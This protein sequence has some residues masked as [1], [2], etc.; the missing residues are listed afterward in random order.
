[1]KTLSLRT[2]AVVLSLFTVVF[3]LGLLWLDPQPVQ[4]LR[5]QGFDQFQR[6]QPRPYEPVGVRVVDLDDESLA[7]LGQWPWPRTRMAELVQALDGLGAAAIG[8]DVVFAEPDRTS[9]RAVVDQW[10]LA[11]DIRESLLRLPDHD[12]VFAQAMEGRRV[13]LGFAVEPVSATPTA[14]PVSPSAPYRHVWVGPPVPEALHGFRSAIPALPVLDRAAAGHGALTFVPDGDGVVRR[15]PLVLR[16]GDTPVPGLAAELLRVGQGERNHLLASEGVGLREVRIGAKR[17]PTN[18]QGEMWVHYS[19]PVAQRYVP[20]WQVLAGVAPREAFEGHLILVGSS[21]QGLMDLRFN[22]LGRLMPGVEAH[23]QALEQVLGGQFL[24]RPGW[25]RALELLVVVFGGVAVCV[26]ATHTRALVAAGASAALVGAVGWGGWWAFSRQ[27]LLLDVLTPM[28]M[29]LLGFGW[30]SLAHHFWS[31]RQQRWIKAAF[32]RYVS[33]NLV[34][35][36]VEHPGQLELGGRRQ[37]CSF[38]F[39]DL[40]GFTRLMEQTDPARAVALLNGYLDEMIAIAFRHEGTLDRIVGDAVAIVFSAPLAQPDHAR[41]ALACA[42]EMHDFATRYANGLQAQG[43]P[44]GH[45]RLGVHTGEVI[46]GNFGGSTIFD[47]RA[48]GDPVNTAAR[49]E[50]VNKHLGTRICVSEATLGGCPG[51]PARPVGRL[52]LMGK[53][54]PLMVYE[55]WTPPEPEGHAPEDRYRAAYAAMSGGAHAEARAMLEALW[56]EF[57]GDPLVRLHRERLA[58]GE[59]GDLIVLEAK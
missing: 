30:S 38:V 24:V 22:P 29:L 21:A 59:T 19:A 11:P 54:E 55:P 3:G 50:S 31:E 42:L 9:P 48:L 47:Y 15:V 46:V 53:T 39:T 32:A 4:A 40:A 25:A 36:L 13:V 2:L 51:A 33:P 52:V 58:R 35:H 45:T 28:L 8:F 6:W 16:L 57:P 37:T 17:I 23:A 18:A 5:H 1:M 41:R 26:L 12:A 49:L 34:E 27:G 20:A 14:P 56:A 10:A 44:F 7:R 43:I